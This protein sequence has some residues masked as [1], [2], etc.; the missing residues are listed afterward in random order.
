MESAIT[1]G[2]RREIERILAVG[3]EFHP[4]TAIAIIAPDGANAGDTVNI[5]VQVTNIT[6]I[7]HIIWTQAYAPPGHLV[8]NDYVSLI[9]PGE[10]IELPASFPMPNEDTRIIAFTYYTD[11]YMDWH[12]DATETRYVALA[13][14]PPPPLCVTDADCP[15]G[16]V[17][18]NGICVKK[19]EKKEKLWMWAAIGALAA[20]A[21]GVM[22]LG[23]KKP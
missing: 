7:N 5:I 2:V 1:P 4:Y 20:T 11:I 21:I 17:C 14:A 16:Y 15:S 12:V 10:T 19:E 22:V 18:R 6:D 13:E 8:I 9:G 3:A 23:G